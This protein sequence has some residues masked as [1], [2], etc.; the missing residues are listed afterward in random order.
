M[1]LIHINAE[2]ISPASDEMPPRIPTEGD[3]AH[4]PPALHV[5]LTWP[6][7]PESTTAFLILFH[8]L[9]DQEVSF[10]GFAKSLALPGVMGISV[11]GTI[12]VPAAMLGEEPGAT[13]RHFHWGDDLT[14]NPKT[15]DL[16]TDPGFARAKEL[17]MERLV[18]EILLDK[19]GWEL[20][21]IL[22]FG[23]GQGGSLALG[24]A[25]QLRLGPDVVDVTDGEPKVDRTAFKGVISI[26]GPL[27]PSMVP[28]VSS[29]SKSKT[30]V[31]LCQLDEE[32][33]DYVK[34]EFA[35]VTTVKWRGGDIG[36][37]RD[38]EEVL[39]MMKFFADRLRDPLL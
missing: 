3:F 37:P 22:F 35:D 12:P 39:P 9:G 11:R 2:P 20:S 25:S 32:A 7:P 1:H 8:G 34:T 16:D 4:L 21:D 36:M 10:A 29:R 26:G 6:D 18:R 19:C 28:T 33:Q 31:L 15:G 30:S 24:L 13:P 23:F 38:R 5:A 27:P 14:L 17:V